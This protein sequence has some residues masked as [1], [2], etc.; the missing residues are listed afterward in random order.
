MIGFIGTSITVI[1]NY[2]SSHIELL[3]N[4]VCLTNLS[5]LS[6]LPESRTGFYCLSLSLLLEFTNPLPSITSWEPH[7][8]LHVERLIPSLIQLVVTG[9]LCLGTCYLVTTCSLLYIVT[10]TWFP[11]RCSV[12][13]VSLFTISA[14]SRHVTILWYLRMPARIRKVG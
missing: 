9:I 12:T 4:D 13:D 11:S 8:D 2:N 1:V 14:F 7:G 10:E 5:D 6:L 3:L